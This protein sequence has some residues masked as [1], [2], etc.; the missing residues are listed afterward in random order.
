[1]NR[2][3][4]N[5]KSLLALLLAMVLLL[6]LAA[7]TD[8]TK[9]QADG[10][11]T[12]TDMTG[13]EFT[14][15]AAAERVV[16]TAAA[17]CEILYAIGA[18]QTVVG[19]GSYCD[20]PQAVQSVDVVESGADLNVEQIIALDPQ[21]VLMSTMAQ[22]LDQVQ[23]LQDAGIV[24][25]ATNA[26]DIN[27]VYA[28]IELIGIVVGCEDAAAQLIAE[29]QQ[30]FA[31]IEALV[32]EKSAGSIYFEVSPLQYGLWAAGHGTYMHEIAALLKLENIFF[33]VEGW[34]MVSEEQVISR[35]PDYIV[36][37]SPYSGQGALP[38]EEILERAG[39]QGISAV[40][41]S[42]VYVADSNAITRPGPRL[43]EAARDL[44]E[45]VYGGTTDSTTESAESAE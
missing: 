4:I 30:S 37:I 40:A 39:W 15:S 12:L 6:S 28:A 36:T 2:S 22:S 24:V 7:C 20:Y 31:E 10:S 43:V 11:I 14:L 25:V 35:N 34:A 18:G 27:G 45:F 26:T 17:D 33:D 19:R 41:G 5:K 3:F 42:A 9:E 16:V 13:R 21:V 29:M 23:A 38:D 8:K 44:Y 32:G 1:M